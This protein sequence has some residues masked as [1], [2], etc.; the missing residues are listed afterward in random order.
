MSGGHAS[1]NLEA[2]AALACEAGIKGGR[3]LQTP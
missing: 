3:I 1:K 2:M